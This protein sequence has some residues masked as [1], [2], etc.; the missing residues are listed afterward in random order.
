M[1]LLFKRDQARVPIGSLFP[2][3]LGGSVAFLLHAELEFSEEEMELVRHYYFQDA[4]LVESSFSEDLSKAW[5]S[6]RIL[7]MT[8]ACA[9]FVGLWFLRTELNWSMGFQVYLAVAGLALAI[10][11]LSLA[12]TVIVTIINF[13]KFRKLITVSQ[14]LH[15]GRTF[16][17]FTVAELIAKEQELL[18]LCGQLES[19]V[20]ASKH[21]GGREVN[22]IPEGKAFFLDPSPTHTDNSL[23]EAMYGAGRLVRDTVKEAK[24]IKNDLGA[25]IAKRKAPQIEQA[26]AAADPKP[27]THASV[28]QSPSTQTPPQTS[29]PSTPTQQ[30]PAPPIPILPNKGSPTGSPDGQTRRFDLSDLNKPPSDGS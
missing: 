22:P 27:S 17:C 18:R 12:I 8:I 20:Q 3:R 16:E 9:L 1:N 24:S 14:L 5:A 2:L 30:S 26:A 13:F 28:Q 6:A 19:T 29:S 7:G 25:R 23:V 4:V 15:G 10:I 21:W 11:V